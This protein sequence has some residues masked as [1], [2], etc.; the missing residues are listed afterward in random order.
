MTRS[1]ILTLPA[2]FV[3][4]CATVPVPPT[5]TG[6]PNFLS[7]D[8]ASKGV[9]TT[10]SGLQYFVV[11]LGPKGGA[12]PVSGDTVNFD[13][14]GKLTS[15]DVFDSSFQR[16]TPISGTVDSFV[17]GFNEALK[18]MRPGAEWVVWIP[19]ALGYGDRAIGPIPASS[20]LRF[21]LALHAVRRPG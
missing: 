16:G 21:R 5:T 20:V 8:A 13:Y 17:P 14:E 12:S 11:Q 4:A 19:P 18:L 1:I 10:S 3:A 9:H 2:L 6:G 7:R 15:G